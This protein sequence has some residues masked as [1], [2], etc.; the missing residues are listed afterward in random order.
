[1]NVSLRNF[2]SKVTKICLLIFFL[3]FISKDISAQFKISGDASKSSANC[4]ELT[5]DQQNKNG[6]VIS[7]NKINVAEDFTISVYMNFGRDNFITSGADGIAFV[8]MTDTIIPPSFNGGGLGY[9]GLTPSLVVEFD[10]YQNDPNNDPS[11]DHIALIRNGSPNHNSGTIAGPTSLGGGNIEDND[12]HDVV[13]SWKAATQEFTVYFDCNKVLGYVGPITGPFFGGAKEVYWGFTAST[14]SARNEQSFCFKS[15]SWIDILKDVTY[16]DSSDVTL[17]GGS[18]AISYKW[19]PAQGLSNPFIA[20]PIAKVKQT[21]T[22]VLEKTDAC[23]NTTFDSMRVF[24]V[25]N[26]IDLDLGADTSICAGAPLT[27]SV[28]QTGATYY[29]NT[30]ETSRSIIV[31]EGATYEVEVDDGNC[32]KKD[33]IKISEI[34]LPV[35]SVSADTVICS[36][37]SAILIATSSAEQITW[38]DGTIGNNIVVTSEGTYTASAENQCGITEDE[39]IVTVKNCD[40]YYVPNIFSPNHDGIN[41]YFGPTT[42]DAIQSILRLAIYDRWGALMYEVNNIGSQEEER[43]WDGTY[44]GQPVSPGVYVYMIKLKLVSGKEILLKGS[45]SVVN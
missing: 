32:K 7:R 11:F 40:D 14:G 15:S 9:E 28:Q 36:K 16:C 39:V 33:A 21:T 12:D 27:L 24:I 29:W 1:M 3:S 18:G 17:D 34:P 38:S 45:V 8:M 30:G 43:M 44:R 4:Y 19:T 37:T 23:G 25:P 41:D 10:T 5:P 22:F 13:F 31:D 26:T 20:K 35:I 6:S 42:S 2:I